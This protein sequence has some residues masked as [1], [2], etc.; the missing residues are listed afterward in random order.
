MCIVLTGRN[1]DNVFCGITPYEFVNVTIT[2]TPE[3]KI[4]EYIEKGYS[5]EILEL[6]KIPMYYFMLCKLGDAGETIDR[7]TKYSLLNHTWEMLYSKSNPLFNAD[8]KALYYCF[9]PELAQYMV[10]NRTGLEISKNKAAD[11]FDS[12]QG[13]A[14][15]ILLSAGKC[16]TYSS[17]YKGSEIVS[18][19]QDENI[20]SKGDTIKF[21]H[22]DWREFLAAFALKN[23]FDLIAQR[24][25]KNC[26]NVEDMPCFNLNVPNTVTE[27]FL[28]SLDISIDAAGRCSGI[29]KKLKELTDG[30]NT[31]QPVTQADEK[32][33]VFI[34]SLCQ[35]IECI[36]AN[37]KNYCFSEIKDYL[38]KLINCFFGYTVGTGGTIHSE[39]TLPLF[40]NIIVKQSEYLRNK[41]DYLT[42]LQYIKYGQ[43]K[44]DSGSMKL[45]NQEG[46]VYLYY[47]QSCYRSEGISN[48]LEMDK[49]EAFGK[50]MD[51]IGKNADK[52][53]NMS[54]NLLAMIESTPAPFIRDNNLVQTNYVKAFW[55]YFDVM[56]GNHSGKEL[57]YSLRQCAA[58]LIKGYV[59]V[60][61]DSPRL[62]II[63][64]ITYK[65]PSISADVF[66]DKSQSSQLR[67]CVVDCTK[68]GKPD[69]RPDKINTPTLNLAESLLEKIRY[70]TSDSYV[71]FLIGCIE[72]A[73]GNN[74][75]AKSIL[76]KSAN[77]QA[78]I[79]LHGVFGDEVC[80][81]V[82]CIEAYKSLKANV[83]D[84]FG[85][86]DSCHISYPIAEAEQLMIN[87]NIF[88]EDA[89][90]GK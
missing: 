62:Q 79:I 35:F 82:E 89:A 31:E 28:Q 30:L 22:Q 59:K 88:I 52:H 47:A 90:K 5:E 16:E 37:T 25:N 13:E 75:S 40:I 74:E 61:E 44:L 83:T 53:N 87:Y 26:F 67:A 81:A 38:N 64:N 2:G 70:E 34:E 24:H 46:K 42:A 71:S 85:R 63:R 17:N 55:T 14:V 20:V 65:L 32:D 58:L 15:K 21:I 69:F 12:I 50:G 6:I 84:E 45:L 23:K 73:K 1:I 76:S 68:G 56:N 19:L 54:S 33:I 7:M 27:M 9:A 41:K 72:L 29:L 11:I 8:K 86:I 43:K 77:A 48:P 60:D 80:K 51:I 36:P 66:K 4:A 49:K 3:D 10:N 57:V 78:K 18:M 39:K